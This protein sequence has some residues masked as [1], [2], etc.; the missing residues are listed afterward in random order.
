MS[1]DAIMMY[2]P[3]PPPARRGGLSMC[4][5]VACDHCD[6]MGWYPEAVPGTE[7][8]YIP[9]CRERYCDCEAGKWRRIRD[10]GELAYEESSAQ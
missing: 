4:W 2:S 10:G 3:M 5:G 8:D 1:I 6:G 9:D 7:D